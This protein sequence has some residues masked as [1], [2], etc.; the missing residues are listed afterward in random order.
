MNYH[1]KSV[2]FYEELAHSLNLRAVVDLSPGDDTFARELPM[3]SFLSA[4]CSLI[5]PMCE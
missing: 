3:L 5:T 2:A 1:C 4:S